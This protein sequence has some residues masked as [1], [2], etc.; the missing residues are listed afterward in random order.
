MN[1]KKYLFQTHFTGDIVVPRPPPIKKNKMNLGLSLWKK[2]DCLHNVVA[3]QI[4][5]YVKQLQEKLHE[6]S[7]GSTAIELN[8]YEQISKNIKIGSVRI[9]VT[10]TTRFND[11]NI[12]V[13]FEDAAFLCSPKNFGRSI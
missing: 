6:G 11:V 13:L 10:V 3:A 12:S 4:D 1:S 2:H 9:L 7:D 8:L 5:L